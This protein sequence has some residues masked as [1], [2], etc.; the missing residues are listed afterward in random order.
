M[1][2]I[3]RSIILLYLG[4]EISFWVFAVKSPIYKV[5]GKSGFGQNLT[6]FGQQ[7]L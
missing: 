6:T 7:L 1:Q 3:L 2:Y 4:Y 5:R